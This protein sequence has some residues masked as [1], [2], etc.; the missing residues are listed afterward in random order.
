MGFLRETLKLLYIDQMN[1]QS[2]FSNPIYRFLLLLASALTSF[3]LV[4]WI[5][6]LKLIGG[7]EEE[8]LKNYAPGL[9]AFS[10]LVGFVI[11]HIIP[12]RKSRPFVI[13]YSLLVVSVALL[14]SLIFKTFAGALQLSEIPDRIFW[15]LRQ[16]FMVIF[17][18]GIGIFF[19][20]AWQ[21]FSNMPPKKP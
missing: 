12:T 19:G 16:L 20:A 5:L 6:P 13:W 2:D 9:S 4:G 1:N 11:F 14:I 15:L 18:T 10:A 21:F 17:I 7:P 3:V 8:Q